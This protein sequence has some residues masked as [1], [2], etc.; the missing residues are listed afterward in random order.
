MTISTVLSI[1]LCICRNKSKSN[2]VQ[3]NVNNLLPLNS[4]RSSDLQTNQLELIR[5]NG[6]NG[7]ATDET[8]HHLKPHTQRALPD[9]PSVAN[10]S[11]HLNE[12]DLNRDSIQGNEMHHNLELKG[13]P[14]KARAPQPPSHSVM[15]C[16]TLPISDDLHHSYARIKDNVVIDSSEN[17]TDDYCDPHFCTTSA[18]NMSRGSDGLSPPV[19]KKRFMNETNSDLSYRPSNPSTSRATE[20]TIVFMNGPVLHLNHQNVD[21]FSH[22]SNEDNR[23]HSNGTEISYNTI[24]VR[25]PLAK[26]LAER[27]NT[28]HHYNEVEE[29]RV[30]SFYEEIAGSTASS[31][32]YSKIGDIL[33]NNSTHNS[34]QDTQNGGNGGPV[35]NSFALDST[36]SV[37]TQPNQSTATVSPICDSF[38]SINNNPEDLYSSVDKKMK[39][40]PYYRQTIHC[41]PD[42][43]N[44]F[45]NLYAKVQKVSNKP[46]E[47]AD[48]V[49]QRPSS[50]CE[51]EPNVI[52]ENNIPPPLP[53]P[54]KSS[55]SR[56][57][58]TIS[59]YD[60]YNSVPNTSS[61]QRRYSSGNQS[62]DTN[63]W[64]K[65]NI[66]EEIDGFNYATVGPNEIDLES[67]P[68]YEVIH[69]K[70][71][72]IPIA[73]NALIVNGFHSEPGVDPGYEAIR[74]DESDFDPNYEVITKKVNTN[75][76]MIETADPGYEVIKRVPQ[77]QTNMSSNRFEINRNFSDV[78]SEPGYERIRFT[79]KSVEQIESEPKYAFITRN[80]Q[81]FDDEEEEQT[82]S[83]RL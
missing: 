11:Q 36:D 71:Q 34:T 76:Q 68:G 40:K 47:T 55:H 37:M 58:R 13:R 63:D 32:T 64:H 9:I 75:S 83:E 65:R 19:P 60:S 44:E 73:S 57:A 45:D 5:Y 16:P 20:D 31:V 27:A 53:P 3:N 79:Q 24:S 51:V 2:S 7:L 23:I 28:E 66:E 69:K 29:E 18:R 43:D 6:V 74:Y 15:T 78:S 52:Q 50:V 49:N 30:S 1:I 70:T 42:S 81:F 59:L 82:L 33:S 17:E 72:K 10:T 26:V 39:S 61:H 35:V 4:I 25:E 80:Q 12:F 38:S 62:I 67:D 46:K 54:L 41:I 21:T 56:S 14:P 48:Y 22:S 77:N 8:D